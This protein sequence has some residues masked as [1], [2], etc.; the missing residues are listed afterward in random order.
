MN[1]STNFE[2]WL[3]SP[4][5][6]NNAY[7][8]GDEDDQNSRGSVDRDELETVRSE[9]SKRRTRG[10]KAR[11]DHIDR[12]NSH[13]YSTYLSERAEARNVR[14]P[15]S[16]LGKEFR[17]KFRVP[18]SVFEEIVRDIR[19]LGFNETPQVTGEPRVPLK[20]FVL[21]ALRI[22][23]TGAPLDL[24]QDIS[25]IGIETIRNFMNMHFFMWGAWKAQSTIKM[26]TTQAE[27]SKVIG[28]YERI[29]LPGC[30]GSIDCVHLVW[31]NCP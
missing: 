3:F 28:R 26:P 25:H 27:R 7:F 13:I 16:S 6:F 17:R 4:D 1:L 11:Y 14:D 18:Y 12:I 5:V 30:A 2:Q 19:H 21:T 9:R 15:E 31:D 8:S 22:I 20:L 29:G 24:A 23:A 10:F